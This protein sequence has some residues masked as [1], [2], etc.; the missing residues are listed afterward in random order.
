M[1]VTTGMKGGGFYDRHSTPQ[2]NSIS[3]VL[4]WL[5]QAIA[6][7]VLPTDRGLLGCADYGCSEGKNSIAAK[8]RIIAALRRRT[9]LPIQ[10]VHSDLSTNNFNQLFLNLSPDGKK[11]FSQADV[12]SAVVGGSLYEQLLPPRS[13][14]IA[15]TFNVL[16]WLMPC[17]TRRCPIM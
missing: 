17:R 8:Q 10:T 3:A 5:E 4:P 7:M 9:S 11:A 16:G 6:E 14:S 12:F 2:W 1:P 15:T 13:V